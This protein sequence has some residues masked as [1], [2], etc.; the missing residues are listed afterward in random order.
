MAEKAQTIRAGK[1]GCSP[2]DSGCAAQAGQENATY[3]LP[4][5]S[6]SRSVM[7]SEC[8]HSADTYVSAADD[9]GVRGARER[10]FCISS[11][12]CQRARAADSNSIVLLCRA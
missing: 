5:A 11:R 2:T 1:A 7:G 12:P 8:A 10:T 4:G 3:R 6:H 9:H